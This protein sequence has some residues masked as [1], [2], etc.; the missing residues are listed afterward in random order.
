MTPVSGQQNPEFRSKAFLYTGI[1]ALFLMAF[2]WGADTSFRYLFGGISLVAFFFALWN[3]RHL[4]RTPDFASEVS[5]DVRTIFKN[6]PA[7]GRY[8][9]PGHSAHK[10]PKVIV[11]AS[12]F[13]FMVFFV[14]LVAVIFLE[15]GNDDFGY[16]QQAESYRMNSQFDSAN[17]YYYRALSEDPDNTMTYLGLGYNYLALNQYDSAMQY[18]GRILQ[19]EPENEEVGYN[20]ALAAYYAHKYDESVDALRDIV[21]FNESNSEAYILAGHNFY[22]RQNYDSAISWYEKGYDRGA[23]S[24]ELMHIMGYI[25]QTKGST[26]KAAEFYKEA[27]GYDSTNVEIYGR[28]DEILQGEE[29]ALYQRLANQYR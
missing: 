21:N 3:N 16:Y 4:I 2:M 7:P 6:K 12:V 17:I 5:D 27:I 19:E 29:K 22:D 23:R 8:M 14:I 9:P 15:S 18:F 25:Y 20:Y 1:I 28:L 10:N 13:I 26:D 24:T 11:M